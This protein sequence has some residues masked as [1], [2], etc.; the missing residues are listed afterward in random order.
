[1]SKLILSIAALLFLF[2]CR[3]GY[4]PT[5]PQE[6]VEMVKHMILHPESLDSLRKRFDR[7]KPWTYNCFAHDDT[8][9]IHKL[10]E[11]YQGDSLLINQN[12]GTT[13]FRPISHVYLP[14]SS[15]AA[16]RYQCGVVVRLEKS[17]IW[18]DFYN[19]SDV[20]FLGGIH[21]YDVIQNIGKT[22]WEINY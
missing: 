18:F 9:L 10:T 14:N 7:D 21:N 5:F 13:N 20:W 15:Y 19:I 8:L 3:S 11:Y 17:Y 16:L 6:K 12:L 2:S 4:T 22:K 1:M